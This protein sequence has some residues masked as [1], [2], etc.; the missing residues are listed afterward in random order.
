MSRNGILL[1]N[2]N[3]DI[4]LAQHLLEGSDS[5][6][7]LSEI[8]T[9]HTKIFFP[10]EIEKEGQL[11]FDSEDD[12]LHEA[13]VNAKAIVEL[14]EPLNKALSAQGLLELTRNV[15]IPL[16]RVLAEMETRGIGVDVVELKR[17]RD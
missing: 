16:V 7:P 17:L 12:Q 9:K 8:L 11:N 5:S 10:S 14:H 15:E 1:E 3:L 4:T 13:I 6:E 2:I